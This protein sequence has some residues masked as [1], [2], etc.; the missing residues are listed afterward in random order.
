[1]GDEGGRYIGGGSEF[2]RNNALRYLGEP[3]ALWSSQYPEL[4]HG[5]AYFTSL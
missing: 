2:R 3:G 5:D 1:M 4:L